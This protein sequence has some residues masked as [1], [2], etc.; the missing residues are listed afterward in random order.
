MSRIFNDPVVRL[1]LRA[2]LAGAVAFASKYVD[3]TGHHND[4][5]AGLHAA[6]VAGG[7]AFTEIFTPLNGL[8]GVFKPAVAAA[9]VNPPDA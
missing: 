1:A 5:T 9:P 7:L 6:I 2:I 8:V 4:S 3:K